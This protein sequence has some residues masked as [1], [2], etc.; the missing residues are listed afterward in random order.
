MKKL[1]L[2]FVGLL[3]IMAAQAQPGPVWS[4]KLGLGATTWMGDA[5]D[6]SSAIFNQKIGLGVDIPLTGLVSFQTGVNWTSKGARYKV[7]TTHK[8]TYNQN[9]FEMPLLAAFH[10]GT[11]RN[12]DVVLAAGGYVGVGVAGKTQMRADDITTSWSTFKDV[13]YAGNLMQGLR[14]FDAGIQLGA[15]V[16]FSR[17]TI[18]LDAEFG[19]TRVREEGP[20]NYGLFVT[21]GYKF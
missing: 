8:L 2:F 13:D 6:G 1:C 3:T 19:L 20:R 12:F 10:I 16:D 17:Y 21:A 9:Y 15:G 5:A 18:G 4:V 11:P 7:P 14:R